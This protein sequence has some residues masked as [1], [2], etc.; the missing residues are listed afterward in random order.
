MSRPE[1][2]ILGGGV[3]G[4]VAAN[5]ALRRRLAQRGPVPVRIPPLALCADN[6]AMIAACGYFRLQRG[7]ATH[8]A[9]DVAPSLSLAFGQPDAAG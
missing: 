3:A 5:H 4:G 6:G 2:L 8:L 7:G 9:I 1:L